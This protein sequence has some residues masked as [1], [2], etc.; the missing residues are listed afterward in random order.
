MMKYTYAVFWDN[1]K[2]PA[3]NL[4]VGEF[5][6]PDYETDRFNVTKSNDTLSSNSKSVKLFNMTIEGGHLFYEN[7][8]YC[9]ERYES[10]RA[11]SGSSFYKYTI[12]KCD[13]FISEL[14][15]YHQLSN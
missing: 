10:G 13:D 11:R 15:E 4:S 14:L 8:W 12:T 7:N 1:N 5:G 3:I 9:L 6:K 2:S